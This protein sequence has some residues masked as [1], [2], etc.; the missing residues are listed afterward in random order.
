MCMILDANRCGD[1]ISNNEDMKPIHRWIDKGVG[2]LIFSNQDRIKRE[3]YSNNKMKQYLIKRT[4][5]Q[6]TRFIEKNG[7]EQ[8]MNDIRRNHA[9]RSDDLHILGLAVASGAKL[10]CTLDEKLE[11]DFKKIVKKGT[12][13]K[14]KKHSHLLTDRIC[15]P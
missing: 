1:F 7:V 5:Y 12:I 9:L 6:R 4:R 3:F 8:A 13:Y 10:L 11:E 15:K 2:R 14:N